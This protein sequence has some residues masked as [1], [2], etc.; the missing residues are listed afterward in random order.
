MKKIKNGMLPGKVEF[1]QDLSPKRLISIGKIA[2]HTKGILKSLK[3]E[4][5][6]T[7]LIF[8]GTKKRRKSGGI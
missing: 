5:Y 6:L 2:N 8:I 1:F 4:I 7:S 3:S